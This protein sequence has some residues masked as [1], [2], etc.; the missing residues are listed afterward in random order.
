MRLL[1][2]AAVLVNAVLGQGAPLVMAH[3]A[4]VPA[5][6]LRAEQV[7]MTPAAPA[8]PGKAMSPLHVEGYCVSCTHLI[9][10]LV[11]ASSLGNPPAC[12]GRCVAEVPAALVSG[13]S[14]SPVPSPLLTPDIRILP[15]GQGVY[16]SAPLLAVSAP[17]YDPLERGVVLR[18]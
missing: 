9:V 6:Q 13:S 5:P 12:D 3:E 10:R 17:I 2:A 16:G 7:A 11:P 18:L 4:P 8:V 14:A 1:I 15:A